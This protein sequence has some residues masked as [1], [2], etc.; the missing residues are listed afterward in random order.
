MSKTWLRGTVQEMS[1][2]VYVIVSEEGVVVKKHID[3]VVAATSI[4]ATNAEREVT[5]NAEIRQNL[6]LREP[7]KAACRP[8]LPVGVQSARPKQL[9]TLPRTSVT[10]SIAS[11]RPKRESRQPDRLSYEVL[12]GQNSA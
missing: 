1:D 7:E 4:P 3:H 6:E 12:G 8:G 2:K 9:S 11:T 5:E 10:D